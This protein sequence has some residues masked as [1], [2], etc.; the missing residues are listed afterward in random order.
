MTAAANYQSSLQAAEPCQC[1]G[2]ED[3]VDYVSDHLPTLESRYTEPLLSAHAGRLITRHGRVEA[4]VGPFT[5]SSQSRRVV[6]AHRSATTLAWSSQLQV[7][8][9]TGREITEQTLI[10]LQTTDAA[11]VAMDRLIR[12]LH[13]LNHLA[14]A[15]ENHDLWVSVSLR[16]LLA[17][18]SG[19]GAFFEDL[20]HRCGLGP[21]R[22][23]LVLQ[24]PVLHE[25]RPL[26]LLEATRAY[27]ARGFRLALK[28][29]GPIDD[30]Q[31]AFIRAVSPAWLKLQ[32]RDLPHLRQHFPDVPVLLSGPDA[33]N[34]SSLR[35]DDLIET[36]SLPQAKFVL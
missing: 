20:L 23:V 9:I 3:L 6:S 26:R 33:A 36:D 22:I 25:P 10:R 17:V 28:L 14:C 15:R 2:L 1:Q 13:M 21:S 35:A 16:H 30:A 18:D 32:A 8:S 11:A 31:Q 19:H 12:T 29:S 24:L 4:E 27:A 5:L 34:D 7:N